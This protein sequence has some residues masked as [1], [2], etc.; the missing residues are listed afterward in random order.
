M[1]SEQKICQ[2]CKNQFTI[3][4]EDFGFY[5]KIKVPPPTFCPDC[6]LQRRLMWRNERSLYRRKCN[7]PGHTEDIISIYKSPDFTVYDHEYWFSDQWDSLSFG[8]TYDFDATFFS[9]FGGLLR[10][11]PLNA[12]FDNKSVNSSYCNLTVEHKNCYL[13]SA[14]W[15]NEDSLYSNRISFC[16]D[17]V[18]SY[19][20]HKTE[21][22]YE[23][24]YCKDSYQLFFS[25]DSEACNNSYFLYDCRN[26]SNCI[27]CTNLRNKQYH[28]FNEPFTKEK[29]FEKL[30]ELN[31][32]NRKTLE[33]LAEKFEEMRVRA[34]HR[35][36]H[37]INTERVIGDNVEKSKNC[38]YCFDLAGDAENCKYCH[39]GTYGLKDSYDSGPGIGGNSE[40][41]YE[42]VSAGVTNS[43]CRFGVVVW[44]SNDVQY[45]VNCHD[46]RNLFGCVSLRGKQYCILNKQYTKEE[47]EALVPK[48]IAHM[49]D[50]PYTDMKG[51]EYKYGEF[52]PPVIGPFA[53][54]ETVA[55]DYLPTSKEEVLSQGWVWR[56]PEEKQYAPTLIAEKLPDAIEGV[57]DN[58]AN[59]VIACAHE[60][61][62]GQECSTAFK[63]VPQELQFYRRMKLPLPKLC[64]NCR[65]YERLKKRNPMKLW[66]RT[67]MCNKANHSHEGN[68]KNEFETSYSPERPETVY[69]EECY[70]KEGG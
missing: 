51:R 50:M 46:S 7:A 53:Y 32:E 34:I 70:Q 56:A 17:T 65:H 20:A 55:R 30:A 23:N 14:G 21:Y 22:G 29:Y 15:N 27:C 62:C 24:V 64:P 8:R 10:K 42:G 3:E 41:I 40:L 12:L 35:Y 16:K 45:S 31:L 6:R 47:Y 52:F 63:I 67:C 39:W 4:P 9:Q 61:K 25:R 11:V 38:Y 33:M 19:I 36:A 2:N 18:D 59:E 44:Y 58:I 57:G 68:C 69:C 48:I 43:N 54:N 13:V 5:E 1:N 37:L 26:C 49:N 60:G 66:H 28:I